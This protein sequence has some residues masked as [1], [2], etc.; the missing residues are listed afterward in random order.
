M[1]LGW[2]E[3][4]SENGT[5]TLRFQALGY[6]LYLPPTPFKSRFVLF[7]ENSQRFYDVGYGTECLGNTT[8]WEVIAPEKLRDPALVF[9]PLHLSMSDSPA[10]GHMG[11]LVSITRRENGV[12]YGEKLGR[13]WVKPSPEEFMNWSGLNARKGAI[14]PAEL[15]AGLLKKLWDC[16]TPPSSRQISY[17]TPSNILDEMPRQWHVDG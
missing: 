12:N 10:A 16:R 8:R 2:T 1:G 5:S 7:D 4:A 15:E 14:L 13:V 11:F 17:V 6:D 3:V 9:R